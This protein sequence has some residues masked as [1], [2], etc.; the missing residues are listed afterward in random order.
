MEQSLIFVGIDVS[1]AQLDVVIRPT[2]QKESIS[3]DKAGIEVLVKRLVSIQPALIVLE[4]TGGLE[5]ALTHALAGAELP[6]A[7]VNPR[8]VRDFAKATGQLAKTDI[9]DAAVLARFAEV[10]RPELRS[11]PTRRRWSCE[12]SQHADDNS[13]R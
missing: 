9:I 1:K 13:L 8:Q 4:A 12:P 2:A 10:V 7:V 5:R 11:C 3:N 6:V